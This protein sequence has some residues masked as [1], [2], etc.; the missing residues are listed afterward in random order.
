MTQEDVLILHGSPHQPLSLT[1]LGRFQIWGLRLLGCSSHISCSWPC[2]R[3]TACRSFSAVCPK[4]C[5]TFCMPNIISASCSHSSLSAARGRGKSHV[6]GAT[7]G[8]REKKK[9]HSGLLEPQ[10]LPDQS[11]GLPGGAWLVSTFR[12][13]EG[14]PTRKLWEVSPL[15]GDFC[16]G[17]LGPGDAVPP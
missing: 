11:Q 16:S 12:G 7:S 14:L 15:P 5:R 4:L 1:F 13:Q 3:P 9:R 17:D 10:N 2:S 8:E 6:R